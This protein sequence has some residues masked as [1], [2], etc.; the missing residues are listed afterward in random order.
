MDEFQ[1]IPSNKRLC[2][3]CGVI[4]DLSDFAK[5]AKGRRTHKC[6]SCKNEIQVKWRSNNPEKCKIHTKRYRESEKGKETDKAYRLI[7]RERINR[8]TNERNK[9]R[10]RL[11]DEELLG[12]TQENRDSLLVSRIKGRLVHR[13]QHVRSQLMRQN[14]NEVF[15]KF[16]NIER[17]EYY[18]GCSWIE[19]LRY[20][21]TFFSDD[22]NWTNFNEWDIDHIIPISRA[23]NQEE[24]DALQ[25]YKNLR[26][27][28]SEDNSAKGADF[29][30]K[31]R[32]IYFEW[33]FNEI[34]LPP[35]EDK[36][37]N[38]LIGE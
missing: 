29:K 30:T 5:G 7:N 35:F 16:I 32:L 14:N 37:T 23:D 33:Y 31:E 20:L 38:N 6:K 21:E 36:T 8:V 19:F 27:L 28:L 18:L 26:P 24:F 3:I 12:L 17:A 9:E 15:I 1:L 34:A 2:R 13:T 11:L 4:K 25:H 10:K 22:L